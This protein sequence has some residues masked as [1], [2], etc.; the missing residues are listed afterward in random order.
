MN[1]LQLLLNQ[2][3]QQTKNSCFA[4]LEK[5]KA[6]EINKQEIRLKK[7]IAWEVGV[8]KKQGMNRKASQIIKPKEFN[9]IIYSAIPLIIISPPTAAPND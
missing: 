7:N 6:K 2:K 3:A 9:L 5:Q 4:A 1:R 8:I